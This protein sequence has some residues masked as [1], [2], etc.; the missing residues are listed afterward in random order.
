MKTFT[1]K[2]AI[3]FT[4]IDNKS[5]KSLKE[6]LEAAQI[7]PAKGFNSVFIH[8]S[9]EQYAD[10]RIEIEAYDDDFYDVTESNSKRNDFVKRVHKRL[11]QLFPYSRMDVVWYS[12]FEYHTYYEL[13]NTLVP[14]NEGRS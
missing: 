10:L 9:P 4:N 13:K 7:K 6:F 11:Q 14:E 2:E 3:D 8:P 1:T 12:G 5:V